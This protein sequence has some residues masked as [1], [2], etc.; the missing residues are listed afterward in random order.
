MESFTTHAGVAIPIDIPNCDTDQIIP[1]RFL[2]RERTDDGYE[3]FLFHDLRFNDD[4]SEKPGFI[5][6]YPAYKGASVLVADTNWGCGS[7]TVRS[8]YGDTSK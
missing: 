2:R 8:L 1:A 7:I 4:G 5:F 3:R 6:N